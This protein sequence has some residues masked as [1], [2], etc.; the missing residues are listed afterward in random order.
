MNDPLSLSVPLNPDQ[1]RIVEHIEGPALVIAGAVALPHLVSSP[2]TPRSSHLTLHTPL[3]TPHSSHPAVHTSLFTP[4]CSHLTVHSSHCS[5]LSLFTPL[6]VH[7]SQVHPV[8]QEEAPRASAAQKNVLEASPPENHAQI[9]VHV[10][11]APQNTITK[12]FRAAL[13][14]LS[15]LFSGR[16]RIAFGMDMPDGSFRW[17]LTGDKPS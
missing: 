9:H 16:S 10:N 12:N 13:L 4:R 15:I 7:T 11:D 3:F 2:F 1:L 17:D 6:T 5:H 14:H 8:R